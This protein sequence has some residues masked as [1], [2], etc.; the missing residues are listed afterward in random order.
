[1]Y[2]KPAISSQMNLEGALMG[3]GGKGGGG[4]GGGGGRGSGQV[5]ILK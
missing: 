4:K 5:A 2:S 3:K 1:M